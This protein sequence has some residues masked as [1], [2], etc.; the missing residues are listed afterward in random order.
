[1]TSDLKTAIKYI[2]LLSIGL[3]LL[4][5]VFQGQ[6]LKNIW[7][8]I[9]KANYFWIGLSALSVLIAHFL[10]ALRWRLLYRSIHYPVSATNSYHAVIIGYLANLAV[11]R[12][13]E[14]IRCSVIRKAENV[15]MFASIGTVITERLVDV[16]ILLVATLLM[17]CSQYD[18]VSDFVNEVI[19]NGIISRFYSLN[20]LWILGIVLMLF[21]FIGGMVYFLRQRFSKRLLRI[22]VNLRQGFGSYHAMENK[23]LFY[24]IP[25]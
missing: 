14:L 18:L 10:R 23:I 15:P 8:Q 4:Y 1:M 20:Y 2:T 24:A 9:K 5:L 25:F 11:P 21:I 6:D 12:L 7:D 3:G 22:F 16:L 19:I 13:G 17:L